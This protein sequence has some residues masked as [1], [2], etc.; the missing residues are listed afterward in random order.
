MYTWNDDK[1]AS[2][3]FNPIF[4]TIKGCL[5]DARINGYCDDKIAI[6]ECENFNIQIDADEILGIIQDQACELYGEVAESWCFEKETVDE[7]SKRLTNC[8]TSWLKETKQEP[9]FYH[10]KNVKV[11]D[12][13][14]E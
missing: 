12:F 1:D 7:L 11:I 9:D 8:V 10:I 2:V 5:E 4:D 3:W 6:G 13:F 14:Q